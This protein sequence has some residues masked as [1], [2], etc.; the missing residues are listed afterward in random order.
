MGIDKLLS[1]KIIIDSTLVLSPLLG[2]FFGSIF[3]F[4]VAIS[5][6]IIKDRKRNYIE[7]LQQLQQFKLKE[8][9]AFE[10]FKANI[11]SNLYGVSQN[12]AERIKKF[13]E[14]IVGDT[15]NQEE[16]DGIILI[17]ER[18]TNDYISLLFNK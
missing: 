12:T 13:I 16:I 15:Y 10:R 3:S 11:Y 7:I 1:M 2:A 5:V 8:M 14:S 18:K 17:V 4:V 6:M 9:G